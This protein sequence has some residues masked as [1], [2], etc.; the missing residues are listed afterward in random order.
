[1]TSQRIA[2]LGRI[3][4]RCRCTGEKP[5]T[6]PRQPGAL[7]VSGGLLIP[8]ATS[9][10][11][12]DLEAEILLAVTSLTGA[13]NG[14]AKHVVNRVHPMPDG[15][16]LEIDSDAID[17]FLGVSLPVLHDGKL[18]GIPGLRPRPSRDFVDL[19]VLG[20]TAS[21]RVHGISRTRWREALCHKDTRGV[22]LWRDNRDEMDEREVSALRARGMRPL[23]VMSAVLRRFGLFEGADRVESKVSAKDVE[24]E[25]V[26]GPRADVVAAVL[27][28]SD[29]RIPGVIL[30]GG[31]CLGLRRMVRLVATHGCDDAPAQPEWAWAEL[32]NDGRGADPEFRDSDVMRTAWACSDITKLFLLLR[33]LGM[34]KK[35]IAARTG[36]ATANVSEILR[37]RQVR[38]DRDLVAIA[39]GLRL[40]EEQT[41]PDCPDDIRRCMA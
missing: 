3:D 39:S 4:R 26:G 15:L 10:D 23:E 21:V 8:T 33:K 16:R 7:A 18:R 27:T 14:R 1:M 12:Q 2:G 29:C 28:E 20:G 13:R 31:S 32:R 34:T 38:S 37:G 35:Q 30:D 36:L 17:C 11:Q 6:V 40:I 22:P 41:S 5:R 24:I 9:A 19:R 25:W